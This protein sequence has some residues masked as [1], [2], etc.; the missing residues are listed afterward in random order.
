MSRRGLELTM[1][2]AQAHAAKHGYTLETSEPPVPNKVPATP[3]LTKKDRM[4]RPE[5]E[6][7]LILEAQ[8]R[9][10]DILE[11]RFEGI[12]LAWGVDPATGKQMWYT[13]D[14]VI[15]GVKVEAT[16]FIDTKLRLLETKGGRL[17][18][19]QLVRFRGCRACWPM[20]KFEL[21]QLA[22]GA[23]SHVE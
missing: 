13:P 6:M 11:W 1:Q 8:K 10:G 21:H 3:R 9:R 22:Q 5:R 19:A 14:F 7:A 23:W 15:Y 12:S 2:Q 16:Q 18:Q 20:F 4:T 17:F